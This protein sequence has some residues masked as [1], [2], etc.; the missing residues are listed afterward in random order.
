MYDTCQ[1]MNAL[2]SLNVDS[3]ASR[4]DRCGAPTKV[5]WSQQD[6]NTAYVGTRH[7][8]IQKWDT[9]TCGMVSSILISEESGSIADIELNRQTEK[10]C[11]ACEKKVHT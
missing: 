7:G 6:E 10:I 5:I 11:I 2:F 4:V 3:V 1:P 9:R 8:Y